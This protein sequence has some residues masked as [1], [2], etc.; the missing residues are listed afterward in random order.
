MIW[1]ILIVFMVIG[2]AVSARLKS[3][4][5]EYSKIPTASGL[6]GRE[7]A[8]KMLL[9][10]NLTDVKVISVQGSLTDHYNP[11]NKTVNLS[12]DVYNG[13]SVAAAAVAAHECGHAIQHANAYSWLEL[14]STL[15]PIV[16]FSGKIINI[17]FLLGIFGAGLLQMFSF[18]TVLLI[19]IAAQTMITAFTLITLPVEYDASERALI[20]LKSTGTTNIAETD[21]AEDA[22]TWAA[23]TYLVAALAAI[24]QLAYY[25]MLFMGRRN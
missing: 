25:I 17:V 20:W 7:I 18:D 8:E 13:K 11:L 19:V 5:N 3:K 1:I 14:R 21:K 9:D 4:F 16:S 24:T 22:L 2:W 23:R 15:V 10:N 12:P 6:S